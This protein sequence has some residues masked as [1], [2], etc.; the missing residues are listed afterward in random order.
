MSGLA[1]LILNTQNRNRSQGMF[2]R[3]GERRQSNGGNTMIY[4]THFIQMCFFRCCNIKS[5][6][7]NSNIR[8][9]R[10]CR[11]PSSCSS[12]GSSSNSS[13]SNS[14]CSSSRSCSGFIVVVIIVVVIVEVLVSY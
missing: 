3:G 8:S 2:G 12:S 5:C 10:S 1:V 9:C 11:I 13:S 7:S 6:I 14:S 4:H